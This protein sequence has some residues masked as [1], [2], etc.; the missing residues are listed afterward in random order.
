MEFYYNRKYLANLKINK[1]RMSPL[2][3]KHTHMESVLLGVQDNT[4]SAP[5]SP[6]RVAKS[7]RECQVQRDLREKKAHLVR[8]AIGFRV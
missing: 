4:R 5:F 2:A 7:C 1:N 8:E 6:R 3:I